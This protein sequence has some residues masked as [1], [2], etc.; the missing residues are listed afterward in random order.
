MYGEGFGL[1]VWC[2]MLGGMG[3]WCVCLTMQ[4]GDIVLV[5]TPNSDDLG[6]EG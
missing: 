4:P 5:L 3:L 1:W 6:I 2:G